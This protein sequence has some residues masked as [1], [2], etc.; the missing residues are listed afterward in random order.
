M[1][2]PTAL[3][4]IYEKDCSLEF[5][6]ANTPHPVSVLGSGYGSIDSYQ[7]YSVF[8]PN[9]KGPWIEENV[10][11]NNGWADLVTGANNQYGGNMQTILQ[12]EYNAKQ[13]DLVYKVTGDFDF[14]PSPGDYIYLILNDD[15]VPNYLQVQ[16]VTS[17]PS[18]KLTLEL[19][20]RIQDEIDAF[21]AK[22]S[23]GTVYTDNYMVEM[24]SA[25]NNNGA[26]TMI[27]GDR[28]Y[29]WD[30]AGHAGLFSS[31]GLPSRDTFKDIL[32]FRVTMDISVKLPIGK[33][34]AEGAL[35]IG[36]WDGTWDQY[37]NYVYSPALWARYDHYVLNQTITG[38]DVTD[39]ILY[40]NIKTVPTS[41]TYGNVEYILTDCSIYGTWEFSDWAAG[42][43]YVIGDV[44]RQGGHFYVVT[45]THVSSNDNM[46][47]GWP[48]GGGSTPGTS[49]FSDYWNYQV[50]W[51]NDQPPGQPVIYTPRDSGPCPICKV[52]TSF[53][54]WM[55]MK[56][57]GT[58]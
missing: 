11:V 9:W 51:Q 13:N 54:T 28:N 15:S 12:S 4:T 41:N 56:G 37:N 16:K 52:T 47:S 18:G 8:N 45:T 42:K 57:Y 32:N 1:T 21:N 38:I 35:I 5:G 29:G 40:G 30:I 46:P 55:R 6:V 23:L 36:F 10:K 58:T 3:F 50:S 17:S 2:V 22:S 27:V 20:A 14:R 31:P 49:K 19:G 44:V 26:P 25:V 39:K 7:K 24:G 34:P 43:I 53:R 33:P 48:A